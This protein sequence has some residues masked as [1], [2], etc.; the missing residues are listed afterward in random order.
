MVESRVTKVLQ[1]S[2]VKDYGISIG[3]VLVAVVLLLI[4]V[5]PAVEKIL[6][7]REEQA[8]AQEKLT[9]LTAKVQQLEDF[10]TKADILNREFAH[11]DQAVPSESDV[12]AILIQ[13]QTIASRSGV[14]IAA[15]QFSGGVEIVTGEGVLGQKRF[16]ELRIKFSS[17]SSFA[18]LLR[19]LQT[20]E[21]AT[22]VIDVETVR[23]TAEVGKKVAAELTLLAYYTPKPTLSLETPITFDFADPTFERNSEVLQRLTLYKTETP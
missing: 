3:A 1:H 12:P 10:T 18:D 14:T 16:S 8:V 9:A 7:L 22:R 13:I 21:T 5:R 11:F 6:E 23:Y 2:F 17:E 4:S 15:L 19:L 20:F